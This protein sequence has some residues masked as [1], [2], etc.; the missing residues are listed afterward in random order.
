MIWCAPT[1]DNESYDVYEIYCLRCSHRWLA[2]A[3]VEAEHVD[4]WECPN[5]DYMSGEWNVYEDEDE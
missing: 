4:L 1:S 3:P 2:V 5:C